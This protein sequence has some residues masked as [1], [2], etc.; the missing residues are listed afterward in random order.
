MKDIFT[1][2]GIC[3]SK[4][5]HEI[6]AKFMLGFFIPVLITNKKDEKENYICLIQDIDQCKA[7]YYEIEYVPSDIWDYKVLQLNEDEIDLE[8]NIY[9]IP[10]VADVKI[11]NRKIQGHFTI[12]LK[13]FQSILNKSFYEYTRI[14]RK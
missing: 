5:K 8:Q 10:T 1:N 12:N 14:N 4:N 13:R 6:L 2:F 3:I 7:I 11:K 9:D